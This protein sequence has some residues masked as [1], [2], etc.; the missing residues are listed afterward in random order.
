LKEAIAH[1]ET[2]DDPLMKSAALQLLARAEADRGNLEG[3]RAKLSEALTLQT[4]DTSAHAR[5][6]LIIHLAAFDR[7]QGQDTQASERMDEVLDIYDEEP[8]HQGRALLLTQMAAHQLSQGQHTLVREY[9]EEAQDIQRREGDEQHLAVS[10]YYESILEYRERKYD[11]ARGCIEQALEIQTRLGDTTGQSDSFHQLGVIEVKQGQYVKAEEHLRESLRLKDMLANRPGRGAS[12]V[13]LAQVVAHQGRRAEAREHILEAI[14]LFEET[15]DPQLPA[16]RSV[17]LGLE[18]PPRQVAAPPPTHLPWLMDLMKEVERAIQTGKVELT[19]TKVRKVIATHGGADD[20][21]TL[22]ALH[23]Y[24]AQVLALTGRHHE[25]WEAAGKGL[26]I[27][28][29]AGF[30]GQADE[31]RGLQRD[32]ER[33]SRKSP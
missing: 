3:A 8:P 10:L 28:E 20:P 2:L 27:A 25:A 17:L 5:A 7:L 19:L 31:I 30:H 13:M 12:L 4:P 1:L 18:A 22:A 16:A 23:A 9:L 21:N 11:K 6:A 15:G 26:A 29:E 24:E 32:L 14:T 33:L